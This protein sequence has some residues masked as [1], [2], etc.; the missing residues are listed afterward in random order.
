MLI[1]VLVCMFIFE[2]STAFGFLLGQQARFVLNLSLWLFAQTS[3]AGKQF[4]TVF[5]DE[6]SWY[7]TKPEWYRR[8]MNI[9]YHRRF[10]MVHD[11]TINPMLSSCKLQSKQLGGRSVFKVHP[12]RINTQQPS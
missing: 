1:F 10:V 6:T 9:P 2:H 5:T 7:E 12:R 4:L 8:H 3:V 11:K